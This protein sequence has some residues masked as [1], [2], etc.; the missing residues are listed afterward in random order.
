MAAKPYLLVGL[1]SRCGQ[2][3][4]GVGAGEGLGAG[5]GDELAGGRFTGCEKSCLTLGGETEEFLLTD[6]GDGG[7]STL[8]VGSGRLG[9]ATE[10][11]GGSV[12]R[13][14]DNE[15]G[16]GGDNGGIGGNIGGRGDGGGNE[17]VP[18]PQSLAGQILGTTTLGAGIEGGGET[19]GG[20]AAG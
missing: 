20:G 9:I 15:V 7:I 2:R 6:C 13:H 12:G 11:V 10:G 5:R 4:V 16:G 1:R 14:R 3:R 8:G 19:G 18:A 17:L